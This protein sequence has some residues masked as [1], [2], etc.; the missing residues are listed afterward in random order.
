[1]VNPIGDQISHSSPVSRACL[2]DAIRTRAGVLKK[3]REFFD[4]RGFLEV[5]TPCLV[6]APDPAVHLDSF[7]TEL[8]LAGGRS[9]KL[10]LSTSPEHHMK[11]LLAT[12]IQPR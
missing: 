3:I 10:Y 4:R 7:E 8:K 9:H 5:T 6:T 11:R 2:L 12:G 1:L